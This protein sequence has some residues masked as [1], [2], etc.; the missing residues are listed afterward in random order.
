MSDAA[1]EITVE[2]LLEFAPLLAL[3]ALNEVEHA[4]LLRVVDQAGPALREEFRAEV[5]LF[6]ELLVNLGEATA[7][8]PPVALRGRLLDQIDGDETGPSGI[9]GDDR[10]G[11]D[12]EPGAPIPITASRSRR[13]RLM[14]SAAAAAVVVGI[15]G[16]AIGYLTAQRSAPPSS[17]QQ[18][19]QVFTAPD[20]RTTTGLVAGGRATVTYSPSKGAGVLVM[21]DVPRPSPG[22]IYQM[23]L[24]GPDGSRLAG[25]MTEKDIGTSTTAVIKDMKGATAVVFTVGNAA[26][27]DKRVGDPVAT[28]PLS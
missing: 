27:P 15:G 2:N 8:S 17:Q 6:R 10:T 13:M 11:A 18:A 14:L 26:T 20:V 5:A 9:G 22:Q 7:T 25:T 1:D 24:Q 3:D 4:R 12:R 23:W 21:N 28:L 16:G 19:D